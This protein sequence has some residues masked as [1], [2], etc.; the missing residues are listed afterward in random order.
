M[1][2]QHSQPTPTSLGQ[3]VYA[4]LGVT[5]HLHFWQNGR[6]LLR[7]SA[8][9]RDGMDTKWE[10]AQNVNS[11]EENFPAALAGTRSCNLSITSPA[12]YHQAIP[13][14]KNCRINMQGA[15]IYNRLVKWGLWILS[16]DILPH[17]TFPKKGRLLFLKRLP[18]EFFCKENLLKKLL[19]SLQL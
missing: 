11:G 14:T 3:R 16:F 18:R 15:Y 17:F 8:V 12:L 19:K 6:G 4:C 1:P 2:G 9:T 5:C 10:S 13:Q 7:D